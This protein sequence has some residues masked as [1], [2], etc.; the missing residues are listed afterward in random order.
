MTET[1]RGCLELVRLSWRQHPAKLL[2]ALVLKLAEAAALPLVAPAL[3]VLTDAAIAGEPRRAALAGVAVAIGAVAALTLGHFAHIAYFELGEI[4]FLT[5]DRQLIEL[6]GGSAGL[7][8]HERPEYADKMQTLTEEMQRVSWRSMEALLSGFGVTVAVTVTAVLLARLHPLLL[9]LPLA[10][11]PPMMLGRRAE[12]LLAAARESAAETTRR[13]RHLFDLATDAGPAKELRVAGM[14][15]EIRRRHADLWR[16]ATAT[17]WPAEIRAGL[18]RVGG[19]SVFALGYAAATLLVVR[20]AAAGRRSVGDVVLVIAL[21]ALVNQQVSAAVGLLRDLQRVSLA[22]AD[23]RWLS[24]LVAKQAP[25]PPDA[26]VPDRINRGI[27]LRDVGFSYPGTGRPVVDGIDVLLPA[28]ATV[29]IVGENGAGKTTLVKL[30]CRLYQPDGGGIDVDGVDLARFPLADWRARIAVG[31]QDFV[32]FE[33]TARETVGV[34]DLPRI[35]SDEAVT[36]ALDRAQAGD[37]VAQLDRGLDTPLGGSHPD[38]RQL[39]GG[40]WQKLA[41]GRAMMRQ[42]PLLLILD[43]PTAALDPEAEHQLFERYAANAGRIAAGTGAVTVLVSHRFSTVRMADLILVLAGGRLV[44]AGG[45]DEL[46]AAGGLYAELYAM[47][48]AAYR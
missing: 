34:G 36:A 35:D 2:L 42:T 11:V 7:E 40:Q 37:V 26:R 12:V 29:A 45:H 31:F 43:E 38:G 1:L 19:Q 23:F 10:A 9:L 16:T 24:R 25:P 27:R 18:L 14:A 48:A 30:L 4:N 21:A 47:Q 5:K 15:E 41:L 28:G 44:E 39:S 33:L 13:A 20:D 3:G 22:L 17:L 6:A 32:R 8:H 46:M